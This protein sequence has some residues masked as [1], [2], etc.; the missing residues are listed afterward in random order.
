MDAY[1]QLKAP[2]TLV[3]K[4][5]AT[6][7][8]LH[9]TF[10]S[11]SVAAQPV[12]VVI[13]F[14]CN[15]HNLALY[16]QLLGQSGVTFAKGVT[17]TDLEV[18]TMVPYTDGCPTKFANLVRVRQD[19]GDGLAVDQVLKGVI[20][21]RITLRG[22]QG[23]LI[24]GEAELIGASWALADIA[25]AQVTN[26]APFDTL[27]AL[28]FEDLTVLMQNKSNQATMDTLNVAE[29][30]ITYNANVK[31][32]FYNENIIKTMTLGRLDVTGSLTV[33]W[34]DVSAQGSK[35]Q[36][37]DFLDDTDKVLSLVW[38]LAASNPVHATP[39]YGVDVAT[40]KNGLT[41]NFFASH[42]NIRVTD[43]DEN[44]MDENPMI[45][46]NFKMVEDSASTIGTLKVLAGYAA[47]TTKWGSWS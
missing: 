5:L 9:S 32:F 10:S 4:N 13:P 38:G 24:E 17:N 20:C 19:G 27:P 29:F 36:I 28:K 7:K 8:S 26:I 30:E 39:V 43:Y 41:N 44:D 1:P 6:G 12:P 22:S 31:S 11:A 34:N 45:P 46:M 42:A 23:G 21:T 14:L 3:E 33:P 35:A 40:G 37:V 25:S 2:K 15:A 18:M 47:A 16:F